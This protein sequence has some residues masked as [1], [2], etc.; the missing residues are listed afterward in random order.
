MA[1][2]VQPLLSVAE[3]AHFK[4]EGFVIKRAALQPELL[5]LARDR[6][7]A[8][9]ESKTL[10]RDDPDTWL[11]GFSEDDRQS[12][13]AGMNDRHLQYQWR[14]RAL[15]GDELMV[16]SEC[17]PRFLLPS[18]ATLTWTLNPTAARSVAPAS[19]ALV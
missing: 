14:M 1:D 9:N 7:W 16:S 8:G 3:I 13:S 10:K 12:D 5:A 18:F 6:L 11:G 4:R 15:S 2:A 19:N 17:Q